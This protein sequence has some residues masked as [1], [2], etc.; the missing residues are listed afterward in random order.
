MSCYRIE[1]ESLTTVEFGKTVISFAFFYVWKIAFHT[2]RQFSFPVGLHGSK[3]PTHS[4]CYVT[5]G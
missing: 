3:G 4:E 2:Y 5:V 1:I